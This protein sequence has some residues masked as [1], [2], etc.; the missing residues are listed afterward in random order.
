MAP[1][2]PGLGAIHP[3]AHVQL[4]GLAGNCIR[5]RVFLPRFLRWHAAP[6]RPQGGAATTGGAAPGVGQV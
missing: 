3:V 2:G 1:T 6:G 4:L 5:R